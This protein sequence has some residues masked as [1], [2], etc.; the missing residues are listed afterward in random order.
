MRYTLSIGSNYGDRVAMILVALKKLRDVSTYFLASALYE[1]AA[2]GGGEPY[3]NCV[4]R[5]ECGMDVASLNY[6]CKC[7]ELEAGRDAEARIKGLVP[8]DV[9]IVIAGTEIIRPRDAET[10]YFVRGLSLVNAKEHNDAMLH[11]SFSDK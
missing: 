6:L 7:I 10:S 5:I 9:D 3:M 8:V 1:T 2:I 11:K 4:V